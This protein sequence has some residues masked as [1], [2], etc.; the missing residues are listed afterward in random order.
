MLAACA[1]E[2]PVNKPEQAPRLDKSDPVAVAREI[3]TAYKAKDLPALRELAGKSTRSVLDEMIAEGE[4]HP[5]Y[6]SIFLGYR[7]EAVSAWTGALSEA[8]YSP[9]TAYVAFGDYEE[10]P[11]V[12]KLVREGAAWV[13]DNVAR[14]GREHLNLLPEEPRK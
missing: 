3:L 9:R 2:Q 6:K 13:F 5:R 7:W 14:V 11:M 4:R 1:E 8:R 10:R 12:V